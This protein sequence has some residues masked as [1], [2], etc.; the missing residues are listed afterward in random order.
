[1]L[2]TVRAR[3]YRFFS[4]KPEHKVLGEAITVALHRLVEHFRR[5]TVEFC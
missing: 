2:K 5:H 4:G 1:M 3:Y